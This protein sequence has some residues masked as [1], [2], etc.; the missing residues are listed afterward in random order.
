MLFGKGLK[1]NILYDLLNNQYLNNI[2]R[3]SI[4][5]WYSV[6]N[7]WK[8]IVKIINNDIRTINLV[9][10]PLSLDALLKKHF[11][12]NIY[13]KNEKLAIKTNIKSVHNINSKEKAGYYISKNE[14]L[15]EMGVFIENYF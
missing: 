8:D 11:N 12:N 14:I 2:N 3:A 5:Q 7:I 1:K 10:E 4:L 15:E 6:K 9:S 13:K